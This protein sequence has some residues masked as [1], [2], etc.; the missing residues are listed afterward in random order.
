MS[1]I[2]IGDI[3]GNLLALVDLL[4]QLQSEVRPDDIVVFLGD[5]IDRGPETKRCIDTILAFRRDTSAEVVCLRGNHE[6]CLL[7]TW[8]DFRRHS[9]LLGMEAFE[10][11]ASYST[12]AAS[13]LRNAV[14]T[15]GAELYLSHSPLPYDVF[16]DVVP[17]AHRTFLENLALYYESSDCVCVHGG[18]DPAIVRLQDQ[19]P[20]ALIWGGDGFPDAYDGADLVVYGHRNNADVDA[21]H[22]PHPKT[23]G[24]TI[25]ID[26]IAHGVLTA[27][28][29]PD[30]RIFQ[31]RRTET[32]ARFP[33]SHSS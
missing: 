26:T 24:R 31:S 14:S 3:H 30:R 17:V 28:R 11:I 20:D 1:T 15:A 25:G 7:R 29:L 23:I 10:T 19:L 12:E 4:S 5:Y 18:V 21:D 22:W 27:V 32:T 13:I 8:H 33:A 6:D 2:A 9:W 16:F